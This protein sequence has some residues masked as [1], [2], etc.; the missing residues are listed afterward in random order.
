MSDVL[1]DTRVVAHVARDKNVAGVE[2]VKPTAERG[3]LRAAQEWLGGWYVVDH[4]ACGNA[5]LPATR[6][7]TWGFVN[8][9]ASWQ[10]KNFVY[11]NGDV[12]ADDFKRGSDHYAASNLPA[13]FDGVDSVV[14]GYIA[15]HGVTSGST[16]TM[17][18]GGTGNGGCT[19]RST[20]MSFG[21]NDLRYMFFS[22]CQSVSNVDPGAVWSR[23]A[24]G[25]RAI[26]GY[27]TDIVD[28]DAY[29][30]YFFENWKKTGAKTT[31]AFLDASWRVSHDQ[32]PVAAWFG[33]DRQPQRTCETTRSTFSSMQ[34]LAAL[35]PGAGMTQE[36]S[37]VDFNSRRRRS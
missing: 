9:R 2:T 34:S 12:W 37:L 21:Q 19:V 27:H 15:S 3:V 6:G 35:S 4:S 24:K 25:V 29:G 33:P 1:S 26:L 5:D 28:S 36:R 10:Q 31:D 30:K 23:T 8:G 16:F 22:A 32:S 20:Q 7:D 17:S 14:L 13:G 18:S 11:G